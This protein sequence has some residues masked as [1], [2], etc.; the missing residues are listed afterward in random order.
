MYECVEREKRERERET[1]QGLHIF[2]STPPYYMV[3]SSLSFQTIKCITLLYTLNCFFVFVFWFFGFISLS[4]YVFCL[5]FCTLETQTTTTTTTTHTLKIILRNIGGKILF[6]EFCDYVIQK[7][8][9]LEE[10][11]V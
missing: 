9:A 3:H 2:T 5:A 1:K 10:K 8:L 4:F 11:G 7:K 6:D